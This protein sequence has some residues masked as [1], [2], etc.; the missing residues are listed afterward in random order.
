MYVTLRSTSPVTIKFK[1]QAT[2][3]FQAVKVTHLVWPHGVP[4]PWGLGL[5]RPCRIHKKTHTCFTNFIKPALEWV[6][7]THI[8]CFLVQTI[9]SIHY[10]LW[11]KY[12]LTSLT[13]WF[14]F[15][16]NACLLVPLI[17]AYLSNNSSI[18]S[19]VNP[20][21]ILNTSIKSCLFCL[22]SKVNKFKLFNLSP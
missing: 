7:A 1:W 14:F 11:K 19:L 13:L 18:L 17:L 22:S 5:C 4:S 16:L 15:N 2:C 6:D 10:S 9:Q 3:T 8:Y 20:L 21:Y 12:L